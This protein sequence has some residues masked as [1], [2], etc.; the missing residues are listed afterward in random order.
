MALLALRKCGPQ[1]EAT[2]K[3]NLLKSVGVSKG[4]KSEA[5]EDSRKSGFVIGK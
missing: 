4:S 1:E 5:E 3:L 2:F